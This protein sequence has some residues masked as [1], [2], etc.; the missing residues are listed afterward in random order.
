MEA[1]IAIPAA[2][3][4]ILLSVQVCLWAHA[5]TL[6]Q[7]A[8]T[9]GD[10]AACV[11]GGS[12]AAGIAEA[13]VGPLHDSQPG[14]DE[15]LRT[16]S[17]MPDDEVQIRVTGVTESI[18]PGIH[19]PVSAV[20]VG[21][22]QEFRV[23]R[24]RAGREDESDAVRHRRRKSHRRARS[25]DSRHRF[26]SARVPRLWQ[27]FVG[28][29]TGRWWRSGGCDAAAVAGSAGQAQQAAIAAAMPVLESNHSCADPIVTVDAGS[30]APGNWSEY[31]SLVRVEFS[32][33]LVP[34]LP[35]ATSVKRSPGM[36]RSISIGRFSHDGAEWLG[37]GHQAGRAEEYRIP[38]DGSFT[39]FVAV[40]TLALFSLSAWLS[41]AAEQLRH[42]ALRQGKLNRLPDSV[43]IRFRFKT[44]DRG[45]W[46]S[47]L[48]ARRKPHRH[49]I[50]GPLGRRVSLGCWT[51]RERS[52]PSSEPTVVLGI[53]GIQQIGFSASASATNLHGVTRAD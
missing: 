39:V 1:A 10:Q 51:I 42:R 24:V 36:R 15:S 45:P 41:M 14:C 12:L 23:D 47:T 13:Q 8:A 31:R 50:Y 20:R 44:F 7:A 27:I 18:V 33:L 22:R 6:V 38:E 5:S 49:C 40:L 4:V 35:G 53:V 48:R 29:G 3:L 17:P 52:Y 34:G 9:R 43:Q 25:S 32:D 2:M 21:T 26:V 37:L 11:E 30:F 16:G 46:L 19:L 28:T